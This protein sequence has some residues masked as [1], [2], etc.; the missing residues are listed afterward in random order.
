MAPPTTKTKM[1]IVFAN[2]IHCLQAAIFHTLE[3]KKCLGN[4]NDK[5]TLSTKR[6]LLKDLYNVCQIKTKK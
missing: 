6:S 3:F 1:T 5:L 4:N 2:N